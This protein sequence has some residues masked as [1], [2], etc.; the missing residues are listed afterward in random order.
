LRRVEGA[1]AAVGG[2]GCGKKKVDWLGQAVGNSRE[3]S[4]LT[5]KGCRQDS[6]PIVRTYESQGTNFSPFKK[7]SLTQA[8]LHPTGKPE[9]S[10][11][12]FNGSGPVVIDKY[13]RSS[14]TK[15][16]PLTVRA[17]IDIARRN[18]TSFVV[19]YSGGEVVSIDEGD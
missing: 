17:Q 3:N 7:V 13:D 1:T 12:P 10:K 6:Q 19:V 16:E 14:T 2:V 18:A 5:Y 11:G 8:D 4:G 15:L 9:E